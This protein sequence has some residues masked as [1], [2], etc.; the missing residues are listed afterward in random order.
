MKALAIFSSILFLALNSFA[1]SDLVTTQE[2][3]ALNPDIEGVVSG[4]NVR[5]RDDK[6]NFGIVMPVLTKTDVLD[7]QI[8][9]I[10]SPEV[11]VLTALGQEIP[12]PSNV[13]IPRQSERYSFFTVTLN[14][15]EYTIPLAKGSK[16]LGV[17]EGIFPFRKVV[18]AFRAGRPLFSLVN[19][20]SFNTYT[21]SEEL[22]PLS[23]D[24]VDLEVGDVVI[25]DE[26]EFFLDQDIPEGYV[27]LGLTLNNL[28]T[29][30]GQEQTF[31]PTDLKTL[32]SS[33]EMNLGSTQN[34]T[35]L[36]VMIPQESFD[37]LENSTKNPVPF[38]LSWDNALV[39]N[40][41]PLMKDHVELSN[42]EMI[43]DAQVINSSA[44]VLGYKL[45]IL[46]NDTENG[47]EKF[48]KDF[49]IVGLGDLPEA[50]DLDGQLEIEARVRLDVFATQNTN[51]SAQIS[52]STLE[53]AARQATLVTRYEVDFK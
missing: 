18:D 30:E 10:L 38:T 40:M 11:D 8:S 51:E 27:A 7:F 44:T 1:M 39:D 45:S 2:D 29:E 24:G 14:K 34:S 46:R 5:N 36:V 37:S 23:N 3:E 25:E 15:P 42:I 41:L 22:D 33:T 13:S 32:K 12:V 4:Y 28:N 26:V 31:F 19:D 21:L 9:K 35:P 53:E 47:E 43:I 50:L 52:A 16:Q 49:E 48:E 6:V 20:F 17:L